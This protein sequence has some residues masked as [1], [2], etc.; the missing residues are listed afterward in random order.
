M[1]F[2]N[3]RPMLTSDIVTEYFLIRPELGRYSY[4]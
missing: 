4:G 1:T 3:S 2:R